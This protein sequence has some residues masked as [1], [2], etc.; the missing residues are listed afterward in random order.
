VPTTD[1]EL[2][3]AEYQLIAKMLHNLQAYPDVGQRLNLITTWL[4][5]SPYLRNPLIGSDTEP[6]VLVAT[7]QGFDCV[8]FVET[9]LALAWA[10]DVK[11][12]L[13]VLRDIR[14]Q[15]GTI[16]W[17][18][19]LHYST[20][21]VRYHVGHGTFSDLT[22]GA[23]TQTMTRRLALLAGFPPHTSTLRYFPTPAVP[24][25]SRCI[26]A[27]G[28]VVLFVSTRQELDTFHIG[29]LFRTQETVMLR[30]A[31]RSRGQVVEQTLAAFMH[32]NTMPG[33]IIARPQQRPHPTP[34]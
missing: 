30:H 1:R 6:E 2:S 17:L 32:A 3:P 10:N 29:M 33:I 25:V 31:S 4:L 34:A 24:D 22:Q 9:A 20:D 14:Y 27:D 26:V 15:H 28:D 16:A 7:L 19:R 5:G 21:W 8:T 18:Q 23:T 12:F 13:A 11:D